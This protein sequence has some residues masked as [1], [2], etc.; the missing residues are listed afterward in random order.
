MKTQDKLTLRL[1][2]KN[3]IRAKVS[4]TA[5]SPRAS[6]YRTNKAMSLQLIDDIAGVTLVSGTTL[7]IKGATGNKV[8]AEKMAKE[9]A[10]KAKEKGISK[11]VFDRNGYKFHGNVKAVADILR[12]EGI[13]F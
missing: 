3:R 6:I 10:D 8:S 1:R 2:R 4:G 5:E 13:Q 9:V 11:L 7:S 12:A